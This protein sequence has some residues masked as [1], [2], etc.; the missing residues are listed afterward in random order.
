MI[1]L[2]VDDVLPAALDLPRLSLVEPD[3]SAAGDF[4]VTETLG[5]GGM[6]RV[7]LAS[8]T[9]LGRDVAIKHLRDSE[10]NPLGASR[11]L[12]E[13]RLTGRLQHPNIIPI[14]WI[15]YSQEVGPVVVMKRIRGRS[16]SD[17]LEELDPSDDAALASH[18]EILIRV[19]D[20]VDYAHS[21]GVIHRD[22]KPSNVM[23]GDFGEV[24]VVDW[25]I[26]VE[27]ATWEPDG[28]VTGTPAY[29]APE[30]VD[31][32]FRRPD[33]R[34][35]IFLLGA[36]LFRVLFGRPPRRQ[37]RAIDALVAAAHPVTIPENSAAPDLLVS[38]CRRACELEPDDRFQS[39]AELGAEL[40]GYSL[41]RSGL[42]V[43]RGAHR[44]LEVVLEELRGPSPDYA[45]L[46]E[47]LNAVTHQF[48]SALE[49]WPDNPRAKQGVAQAVSPALACHLALGNLPAARQL[50]D[51]AEAELDPA[52]L[53]RLEGL[54]QA[55]TL[56]SQAHQQV[57]GLERERS[58]SVGR[59]QRAST[60]LGLLAM[61]GATT[62]AESLTRGS[63]EPGSPELLFL[64]GG[65]CASLWG[66]MLFVIRK[67]MAATYVD[68]T[69]T[70][71]VT[72]CFVLLCTH[73]GL[74]L[75]A[76]YDS[77]AI[78]KMDL[79]LLAG[80]LMVLGTLHRR[81]YLVAG[82]SM[83]SSA[84]AVLFP[85]TS[86]LLMNAVPMV[87]AVGVYDLWRRAAGRDPGARPSVT[88]GGTDTG[89]TNAL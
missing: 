20:A 86:H 36:T 49:L 47:R 12:R 64:L 5:E 8:Q 66:V 26:A 48:S 56:E 16:W 39:V 28:K 53:A 76:G 55:R 43:S 13:A 29:I 22:L 45:Q 21:Q 23:L 30:M 77:Y 72:A 59:R 19:C 11:L 83:F 81:F 50:A 41:L 79:L 88:P 80:P 35:D 3:G 58:L 69:A 38:I 37:T 6:G 51:Q 46:L 73:R 1:G 27:L 65:I 2:H 52:L 44:Q 9:A 84:V 78:I 42:H 15:G 33:E 54:E 63:T 74:A 85:A 60:L 18:V 14:H 31:V 87:L 40:R 10:K 32:A 61:L 71:A 4:T 62:L 70:L 67:R 17:A 89:T 82:F 75:L 25:G 24:Y 34:S 7:R 57:E 68:R